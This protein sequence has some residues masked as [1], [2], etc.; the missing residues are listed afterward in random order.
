MTTN[1][2]YDNA[3]TLIAGAM[4][5]AHSFTSDL[6]NAIAKQIPTAFPAKRTSQQH[7]ETALAIATLLADARK[8]QL[9]SARRFVNRQ[10]EQLGIEKPVSQSAAAQKKAAQRAS[11]AAKAP[12]QVTA[13]GKGAKAPVN[14]AP[15][16]ASVSEPEPAVPDTAKRVAL[17]AQSDAELAALLAWCIANR[18]KVAAMMAEDMKQRDALA[19]KKKPT[20]DVSV[21]TTGMTGTAH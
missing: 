20:A 1:T 13:T 15:S 21:Y 6:R 12:K 9:D 7:N 18:N 16:A 14:V 5:E 17:A 4:I 2:K 10:L 11:N 8:I 19:G 3:V